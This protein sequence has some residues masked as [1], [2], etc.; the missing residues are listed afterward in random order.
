MKFDNTKKSNYED[1]RNLIESG[2]LLLCSGNSLF[3]TLIKKFTSSK[4]SHV[5]VILKIQTMGSTP[6]N[7]L[8]VFESV[9]GIGARTVPLSSYI[10][11]YNGTG[12]RYPGE[13]VVARHSQINKSNLTRMYDKAID[14][15]G[16][17]YDKNEIIRILS[18]MI[19]L[20]VS[21][22]QCDTP[23]DDGE[24]I[25]SEYVDECYRSIGVHIK[26]NC[27]FI[28]PADFANDQNVYSVFGV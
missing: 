27:G 23:I 15:L 5:A 2:D 4:W 9:E 22:I 12:K 28:A 14:M 3:S 20:K 24:Y 21:N 11:N 19:A 16:H 7:R 10:N 17:I 18:R 6:V 13:I 26:K 1:V 8:M 25:C